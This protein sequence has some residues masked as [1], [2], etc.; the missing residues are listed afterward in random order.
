[1]FQ[2]KNVIAATLKAHFQALIL[3]LGGA[4]EQNANFPIAAIYATAPQLCTG[5]QV[6][7]ILL[8]LWMIVW[9][10]GPVD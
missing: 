7:G 10:W 9:S 3:F 6:V 5:C 4:S 2:A 1:M 8:L